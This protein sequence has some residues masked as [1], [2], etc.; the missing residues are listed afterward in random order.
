M[1]FTYL[2]LTYSAMLKICLFLWYITKSYMYIHWCLGTR[3]YV[4]R[5]IYFCCVCSEMHLL[6]VMKQVYLYW[7][8]KMWI[9]EFLHIAYETYVS[10]PS[11]VSS[12]RN[13]VLSI[14]VSLLPY[15]L[16]HCHKYRK[17][18]CSFTCKITFRNSIL[19]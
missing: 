12:G 13:Y 16:F 6:N 14:I 11:W 9:L 1:S 18:L 10:V 8:S 2:W 4:F 5:R 15:L 19:W 17:Q 7:K 3:M